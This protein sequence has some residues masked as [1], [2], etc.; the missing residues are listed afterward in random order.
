LSLLEKQRKVAL[1]VMAVNAYLSEINAAG[2][3]LASEQNDCAVEQAGD[4]DVDWGDNL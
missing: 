4:L 1:G 2:V 3:H